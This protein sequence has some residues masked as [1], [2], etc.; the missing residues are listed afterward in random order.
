MTNGVII[1]Q[2]YTGPQDLQAMIDLI[3]ARP[4]A[5][6][7]DY[8]GVLDL[9]E[10]L[11][12]PK[13][14][15]FSRRWMDS[16]GKLAGFVILDAD[17]NSASVIF[18]IA[19]AWKG[20]ALERKCMAWAEVSI[21]QAYPSYRGKYL[22]EAS[23]CSDNIECIAT[24]E[25]LG[26]K[27]Q[28]GGAVHMERSLDDPIAEPQLPA[29]FII[30]PLGGE[31]EAEDWVRLHRAAH[32][33]ENMTVEYKLAMMRTPYYD[34]ALDLVAVAPDGVLA[35]Y[36]VCFIDKEENTLAGRKNGYTD[37]IATHP[38]FQRRGLSKA[39]MLSAL[40]LLKERGMN[41]A[42]L[43]TDSQNIAMLQTAG[44][45]GFWTTKNVFWYNKPVHQEQRADSL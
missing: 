38:V 18:E 10:M 12:V 28:L 3:K 34:P 41:T 2:A 19:P 11:A 15:A 30:R 23:V 31:A 27:R 32:G 33:T 36:C 25:Q 40:A 20:K 22:L 9:Q 21:Q 37:P 29:G 43:G 42:C 5:R 39:L 45:V 1:D 44:S 26:F 24:L 8:P 13:I 16:G 7:A 35:G 17:K 14:Q 4:L 6:A